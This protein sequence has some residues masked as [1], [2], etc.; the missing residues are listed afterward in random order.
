MKKTFLK[1][2]ALTLVLV[3]A[4]SPSAIAYNTVSS[5]DTQNCC[6]GCEGK[7]V[8]SLAADVYSD[9][10]LAARDERLQW[11]E[12][13][14]KLNPIM[15]DVSDHREDVYSDEAL[16]AREER[17]RRENH[18]IDCIAIDTMCNDYCEDCNYITLVPFSCTFFHNWGPWT[19]WYWWQ[20]GHVPRCG[21][22]G[23]LCI[24]EENRHRVCSWCNDMQVQDRFV[25]VQ[26]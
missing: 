5:T 25:R 19:H 8:S 13:N 12:S 10:A 9:E 23:A 1:V 20:Y 3:F 2:V 22:P 11:E 21:E 24:R 16:V 15:L 26:C 14:P 4:F 6:I 7:T 18:S 17:L